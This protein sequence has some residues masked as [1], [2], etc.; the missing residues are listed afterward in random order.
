MSTTK[1]PGV[2][3]VLA[4]RWIVPTTG[5]GTA[6]TPTTVYCIYYTDYVRW[7]S[8][9]ISVRALGS[10]GP[11]FVPGH[12]SVFGRPFIKRFTLC[13]RTVVCPVLS[14][15]LSVCLSVTLV[16]CGQTVGR[17]KMKLDGDPAPQ[18]RMQPPNV[19]PCSLWPSGWME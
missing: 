4:K 8:R 17:I 10:F 11:G 15:C 9:S 1:Y 3:S 16:Y 5:F 13:Y 18:K 7:N 19:G 2:G 6:Q 12:L 14:V